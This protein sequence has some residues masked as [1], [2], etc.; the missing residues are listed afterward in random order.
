[1]ESSAATRLSPGHH[2]APPT[3]Q[4]RINLIQSIVPLGHCINATVMMNV[5]LTK[6]NE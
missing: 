2:M 5:Y 4:K 6:L 1:M 3:N